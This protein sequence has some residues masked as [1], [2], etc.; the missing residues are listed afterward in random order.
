[1]D[2]KHCALTYTGICLL[3][4]ES[5]LD[6]A[7]VTTN[8]NGSRSYGLFQINGR[9]CQ[10]ARRGGVCNVKCEGEL[11]TSLSWFSRVVK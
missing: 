5:D 1:M 6:T 2:S 9:Y 3:E 4:H 11:E 7:K 8:P 10:E